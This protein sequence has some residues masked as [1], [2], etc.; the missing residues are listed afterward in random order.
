MKLPALLLAAAL[1]AP[2][3]AVAQGYP[4]KPV[5]IIVPFVAGGS[6]DTLARLLGARMADAMGQ[7][8]V[9]ENRPGADAI[10]GANVVAKS[11]PD[12]YTL[13]LIPTNLAIYPA[14]Y[15]NLPFDAQKD[16]AP[17]TKVVTTQVVLVANPKLP[18][19]S[20]AELIKLAHAKPGSLNFGGS[21]PASILQ[22]TMQL[23]LSATGMDIRAIP[24]KGDGPVTTALISGEVDLAVLPF[25]ASVPHIKA[26]RLRILGVTSIKR[27][28]SLPEV[29]TIA[30]GG[31][32]GFNASS[33]QGLFAAANTTLDT[34][35]KIQQAVATALKSPEVRNR[36]PVGQDPAGNS[37]QEFD[38]EFR[39]D[40]ARFVK[41]ARDAKL[42][43]QD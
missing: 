15:R 18:A 10:I 8:F 4:A 23:L 33:W 37:P 29:P 16:F 28:P 7:P 34:V 20:V 1:V 19:N 24:Y 21:G 42:P 43:P 12:G 30:E 40:I 35:A 31:V 11:A 36:L 27:S 14:L 2:C 25:S 5:H 17:V 32:P 38:A 9:I 41:L 22:M 3:T 13:L 26:G 6:V 39:G